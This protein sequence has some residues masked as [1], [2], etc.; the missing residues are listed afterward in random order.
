MKKELITELQT[1]ITKAQ[2]FATELTSHNILEKN[3]CGEE[4][5]IIE[6]VD[7]KK[8][9]RK[10]LLDRGVKPEALPASKNF[11]KDRIE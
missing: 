8:E 4:A 9:V 11:P 2:D 7:N 5:I 10:V 6:H 3:L 1:L